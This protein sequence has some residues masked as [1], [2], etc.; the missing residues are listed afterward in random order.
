MMI[1]IVVMVAMLLSLVACQSAPQQPV[2]HH[3]ADQP[4]AAQQDI[5]NVP[6]YRVAIYYPALKAGE[7][8]LRQWLKNQG[9]QAKS[10]FI[11]AAQETA[12]LPVNQ[13]RQQVLEIHYR[14]VSRAGHLVSLVES[15]YS[16]TGGAHPLPIDVGMV[17]DTRRNLPVTLHELFGEQLHQA[18]AV[19]SKNVRAPLAKHLLQQTQ[20]TSSDSAARPQLDDNMQ[21]MLIAGTRPKAD[22]FASFTVLTQGQRATGLQFRF[23]V[24]QV[25]PYVFGEQQADMSADLFRAYLTAPYDKVFQ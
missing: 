25:A 16:D 1:R 15:G 5:T 8:G 22:N 21:Q 18:L 7:T 10:A 20:G 14:V 23:S 13:D 2:A 17:Y 24:Y 19:I 4:L 3:K 6:A 9:N 11:E 12:D